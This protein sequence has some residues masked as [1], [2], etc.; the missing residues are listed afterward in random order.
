MLHYADGLGTRCTTGSPLITDQKSAVTCP[1]CKAAI[2]KDEAGY[3]HA[4]AMLEAV[5]QEA[6]RASATYDRELVGAWL[7]VA[8]V[9]LIAYAAQQPT[10]KT[11]LFQLISLTGH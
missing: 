8:F 7:G 4:M 1:A 9:I 5:A 11:A 6:R 2:A 3:A 10:V